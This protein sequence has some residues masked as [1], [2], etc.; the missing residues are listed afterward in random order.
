M[1]IYSWMML[2]RIIFCTIRQKD[3][4]G[5]RLFGGNVYFIVIF[6]DDYALSFFF[7]SFHDESLC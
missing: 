6:W 3:E 1:T 2:D 7:T 5:L 4:K